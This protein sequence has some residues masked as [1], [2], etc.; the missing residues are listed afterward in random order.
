MI[1]DAIAPY[2]FKISDYP[3]IL[4]IEN[5]CSLEQQDKMADYMR[6]L[7]GDMLFTDPPDD[8]ASTMPSPESLKK[9]ILV[10]AKR[11]PPGKSSEDD[12]DEDEE[13]DEVD[14]KRA[15]KAKKISQKLSDCVNYIHA[16]HFPGFD[17]DTDAKYYH[18]SSF[19]EKKTMDLLEDPESALQFV[20]YNTRQISRIYPGAARQDSSNLKILPPWNAG[21]QIVALNYQTEDKQNFINAAKFADNGQ[22]GYILKP[23]F[24]RFPTAIQYSPLSPSGL[25]DV[26]LIVK[27]KIISGLS[28]PKPGGAVE[29]E[30]VDPYVKVRI[31][32]HPD[33]EVDP[34]SGD[35][36][37]K[38]KTQSIKNNGFNPVWNEEFQFTVKVPALAFLDIKVKDFSQSGSDHD[39]GMFCCPLLT[40]L[41]GYRR[42]PLKS[43]ER[44]RDLHPA[45]LLLHIEINEHQ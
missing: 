6:D 25:S 40:V 10:K 19:G 3:L 27:I 1:K 2:A 4:S 8:A 17:S 43:Y 7:L 29:G 20:R 26:P 33:D 16:V 39:L 35:K 45:S 5:H 38:G 23:Y 44:N 15:K 32:G 22:C 30:I 36:I 12:L 14:E 21:C 13:E 42:A 31:R 18:M 41:P 37:N 11:L 34:E 28:L 9:K 24:L